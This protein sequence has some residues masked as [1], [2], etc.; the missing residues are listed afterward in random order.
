MSFTFVSVLVLLIVLVFSTTY[1]AYRLYVHHEQ[2]TVSPLRRMV[3]ELN[4]FERAPKT[5]DNLVRAI[6]NAEEYHRSIS[7]TI[8]TQNEIS[9]LASTEVLS[10]IFASPLT[11]RSLEDQL[12]I[13]IELKNQG[14]VTDDDYNRVRKAIINNA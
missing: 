4:A 11:K 14:L 10:R 13:I 9:V 3:A 2:S 6:A 1:T 12:V 7:D 8:L 5:T